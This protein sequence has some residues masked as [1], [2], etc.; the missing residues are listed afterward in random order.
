MSV[1]PALRSQVLALYKRL[2]RIASSWQAKDPANTQ[3]ER[4]YIKQ[5]ARTLIQRNKYVSK[6]LTGRSAL[7]GRRLF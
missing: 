2:A 6:I 5:E 7:K 3:T 4:A 1:S